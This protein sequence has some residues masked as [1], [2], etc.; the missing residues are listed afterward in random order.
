MQALSRNQYTGAQSSQSPLNNPQRSLLSARNRSIVPET[1]ARTVLTLNSYDKSQRQRTWE[2]VQQ[3]Y[4]G[5]IQIA[6]DAKAAALQVPG[7]V[8]LPN[9]THPAGGQESRQEKRDSGSGNANRES[10]GLKRAGSEK[11]RFRRKAN[12]SRALPS[13]QYCPGFLAARANLGPFRLQ[14]AQ[15]QGQMMVY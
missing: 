2:Q 7:K 11:W 15:C 1:E 8:C 10:I 4:S 14:R 5:P 6:E 9:T 12:E 3:R 13:G